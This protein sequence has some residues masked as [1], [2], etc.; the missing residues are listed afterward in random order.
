MEGKAQVRIGSRALEILAALIERPGELV[1]K[2][3]LLSRAWPSTFVE[4]SNLKVNVAALRRTLGERPGGARY[5][6]TVSGRGYRFVSPVEVSGPE[7]LT[8][9]NAAGSTRPHNLPVAATRVV[10][11]SEAIDAVL[12]QLEDAR[13]V[14]LVGAGG[15]GKTTVALAVAERALG[16]V[17]HGVWFVDLAPLRDPA[18]IPG[19]IAAALGLAVHSANTYAALSAFLLGRR[20]VVVLDNCE[21][22]LVEPRQLQHAAH[23]LA[24][25]DEGKVVL[26]LARGLQAF[27]QAGDAGRVDIGDL[28]Q[29]DHDVALLVHAVEQHTANLGRLF[30]VDLAGEGNDGAAGLLGDACDS[31]ALPRA[32]DQFQEVVLSIRERDETG[33][34]HDQA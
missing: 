16:T 31:H 10:G 33:I 21:Q 20:L 27:D 32:P 25:R 4:E 3:E 28:A 11:R 22:D 23:A 14:T 5:I 17:E 13:L 29:I 15:I 9:D 30:Y 24:D 12:R 2:G 26:L 18:L 19:A 8:R 6:A 1:S 7:A 34:I